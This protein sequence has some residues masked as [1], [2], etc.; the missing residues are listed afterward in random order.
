M[1]LVVSDMGI[2]RRHGTIVIAKHMLPTVRSDDNP[3]SWAFLDFFP[4]LD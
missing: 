3:Q 2:A 1:L 4:F